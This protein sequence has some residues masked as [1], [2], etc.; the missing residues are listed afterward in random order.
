V[1]REAP[2]SEGASVRALRQCGN[3]W[4]FHRFEGRGDN[5][6]CAAVVAGQA[7]VSQIRRVQ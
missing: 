4:I 1:S 2:R 3:C 6:V 7:F 5:L